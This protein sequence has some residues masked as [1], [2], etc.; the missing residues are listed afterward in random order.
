MPLNTNLST[1]TNRSMKLLKV[2]GKATVSTEPDIVTVSF[3]V[4]SQ[5]KGYGLCLDG[6]NQQVNDLR[7]IILQAGLNDTQLKTTDFKVEVETEYKNNKRCFVGYVAKHYMRIELAMDKSLL[8]TLLNLVAKKHAGVEVSLD[9]SVKDQD[10]LRRQVLDKAVQVAKENARILAKSA[11]VTLG[12]LVQIDYGWTE[13]RIQTQDVGMCC[14][15][16]S[17]TLHADIQP[18]DVEANDTVTLVYEIA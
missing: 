11:G 1:N 7:G 10:A 15:S 16:V 4:R 12:S 3:R 18:Q 13:V 17:G 5:S 8:N 14:E 9:F 6:L 2:I